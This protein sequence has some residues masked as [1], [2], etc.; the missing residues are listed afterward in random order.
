MVESRSPGVSYCRS[1]RLPATG[2]VGGR[3]EF[4]IQ[5]VQQVF[6]RASSM[7]VFLVLHHEIM[8]QPG[9]SRADQ[10]VFHIKSSVDQALDIV[11]R[12][13]V[14]K[15]SWW[16]IQVSELDA[17]EWLEHVGYFGQRG[18]RLAKPPFAKCVAHFENRSASLR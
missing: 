5:G 12:S 11:R 1:E 13:H 6:L 15:W 17:D 18:G 9:N 7:Q 4:Q 10:M 14:A 2:T 16:E 8:G 3:V